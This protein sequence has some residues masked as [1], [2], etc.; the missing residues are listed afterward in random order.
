MRLKRVRG[1]SLGQPKWLQFEGEI[2][3]R[4]GKP[5]TKLSSL[6]QPISCI[7]SKQDTRKQQKTVAGVLET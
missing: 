6:V 2:I 1:W 5:A 4:R 3:K 7:C